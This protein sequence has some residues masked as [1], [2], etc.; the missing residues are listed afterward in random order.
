VL[1]RDRGDTPLEELAAWFSRYFG[2]VD[3]EKSDVVTGLALAQILQVGPGG[4]GARGCRRQRGHPAL[5]CCLPLW[6]Q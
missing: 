5:A 2:H 1:C 4:A 6:R 3:L